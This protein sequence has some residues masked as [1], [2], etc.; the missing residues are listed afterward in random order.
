MPLRLLPV[1]LTQRLLPSVYAWAIPSA[2]AHAGRRDDWETDE[3][4]GYS[5]VLRGAATRGGETID[6][7]ALLDLQDAAELVVG[8]SECAGADPRSR[9]R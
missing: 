7:L 8:F 1:L 9:G 3:T 2:R 6:F 4:R 5:A